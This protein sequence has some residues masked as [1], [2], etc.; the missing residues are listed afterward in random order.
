MLLLERSIDLVASQIAVLKIGA[1]YVPIDIKAP[2][3]RQ[4]YVA[5]DCRS[6]VLITDDSYEIPAE[7]Q[8]TVLRIS[9]KQNN[10]ES[11][12]ANVVGFK[13]YI[14]SSNDTAYV[15][16]TSGSTGQPKGVVVHHRGIARLVINNGLGEIS[17]DDRMAFT[18]NPT[19]DTSINQVWTPLLHGACIVVINADTFLDPVYLADALTRYQ[20]T[21]LQITNGVLH[22]YA[23]IIGKTLSKLKYLFSGAE[24]GLIEAYMAVLQHGGPVRLFNRYGPTETTVTATAYAVSSTTDQLDRL[25]IGKPLSNT[26]V[27]VL[28][29]HLAP[30]PIGVAGELC[31]GGP[32]VAHG[33]LNRPELTAERFVAD[34]FSKVQGARMYK[35]GDLVRYL[36]DGNLIF[37]GRNDN[38]VKIRGYRIELGEIETRLAEHPQV[39]EAVV[40]AVGEDSEETRLVAYVV[41]EPYEELVG[42]LRECLSVNLPEYMIPSAFVRMDVFPLT[43]NG[44]IDRRALPKPDSDSYVTC[45]YTEPQGELEVTLAAIWSDLLKIERVGRHDNFFMLGGHSLLALRMIDRLRQQGY[46]LSVRTLFENPSLHA[47]AAC[48]RLHHT[49]TMVPPNIISPTTKE[50][51]PD[52]LPL[53]S[54]TQDDID[55]VV[56]QVSG[57]VE[58]I[59][60][61]YALSPLQDG[62]LFHHMMATEGDTYLLVVCRAF[63]DKELL[64]R[65]LSAYQKV[66]DRHDS[67]RTAIVWEN[68]ST[69]AQVVLRQATLSVVE[70]SLDPTDGPIVDQLQKMYNPHKYRISLSEAPLTRF[71]CAQDVDGKW[72]SIQLRHHLIS[73][74]STLEVIQE[75][76]EMILDG[77]TESLPTPQPYRNLIGQIH[78]GASAEEH[79]QFFSTMLH[80]IDSPSLPFGLLDVYD[81]NSNITVFRHKLPQ[82][83]NN[84]L[85]GHSKRL[86]VSLASLCH[87]AWAQVVAA[88]S[89][90]S[91][92]VFGTVLFGRMQGGA[93]SDRTLGLFI[94]TLPIRVNI[95]GASVLDSARKVHADLLELLE[96][97][98]ASLAVA[99]RCSGVPPRV[100][101]FSSMLN[102]RH[103]STPVRN[104]RRI[105]GIETI[106]GQERTNYPVGMAVEDSG[107]SLGLTAKVVQPYEPSRICGYMEQ[108]LH[109]LAE[110]LER[111]SDTPIQSLGVLPSDEY[112][113]VVNRWNNTDTPY[114]SDQ[115]VHWLFE[116][117]AKQS[118]DAIA[119]MHGDCSMTYQTLNNC[120]SHLARKL[121]DSGVRPGDYVAIILDRSFELIIS[122]LAILKVGAAYAPIDT[123]APLDRQVYVASDCG[124]VIL[125]TDESRHIHAEFQKTVLRVS[126]LQMQS[127]G[128]QDNVERLATS[129]HDKA[130]VMY[131]SG[132][133]GR[134]KGV[135][136]SHHAVIRLVFNDVF[137][138]FGPEDRVAFANNPSFDPSTLDVWGPLLRGASVVII[139]H[140]TY[141]DARQFADALERYQITTLTMTNAIFHQHAFVIGAAL[142]NLKYL[143]SGAEQGSIAAFA[144]V[145]RHDGPVNLINGYGPTEITMMATAYTTTK[146]ILDM[147]TMPIGRPISNNRTYVLDT[148]LS[149]VPIGVLGE[150]YVGGPGIATGYLNRPELTAERFIPDPFANV[151]GARMYKTG[152]IVRYLPDGNMVFMGRNDDQVKI[153]GFR[154]ELG[155]IEAR[156]AEHPEV[157]ETVVLALGE[158]SDNKKLVAYVVAAHHDNLVHTLHDFLSVTLPEY[159]IPSAFVRMDVFPLT[160]NGKVD[161]RALPKPSNDS[162]VTCV[163]TEP[164]GELE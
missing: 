26:R 158:S 7:I 41:A 151:K 117:Q 136:A 154:V 86:G 28:D 79:E 17:P 150:L 6:T 98:H 156:L 47:L 67:L 96:H 142:S 102:Y 111:S 48:L 4:V 80:D 13:D 124:S 31:I 49:E 54:L 103:N 128:V 144:E 51:T 82:D 152:D 60:D 81:D 55:L 110:S 70:H 53:I 85:R 149:P 162:H 22:Q 126:A 36:A 100:P 32:G 113:L 104:R 108:A 66:V 134:P 88:T 132:S 114:P 18:A 30:V 21:C 130:Y 129:C 16:Y 133:T 163:Y 83:L 159:L 75:E 64:D 29:R 25:P 91:Q 89:G 135:V 2:V 35:T 27:Y 43:N 78:V 122:Q 9:M 93:G 20:V 45:V 8:G 92:V 14:P 58:N 50:L 145:L 115:C 46:A 148:N 120:A 11:M 76:I 63:R 143:L 39:R 164:Q 106:T 65:Y 95:E 61:I 155:E 56:R 84:R 5:S 1:A 23:F 138:K 131:T 141:L 34:P 121:V 3:D 72:I 123:K 87:L 68:M 40:L 101:L 107:S 19:F 157:R 97:E 59:Q 74:H 99:Q 73:D 119:V 146:A 153:R 94:N 71:A 105:D 139:D 42:T 33:Y 140:E 69:P 90:Q 12:H 160:N 77:R 127:K 161:R 125:I 62:I 137:V 44:K 10:I 52:M 37:L 109:N 24:Q 38:Q 112:D 116:E 57:G 15:I 118:P 147:P